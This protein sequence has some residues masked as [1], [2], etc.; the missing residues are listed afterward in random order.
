MP[1]QTYAGH[2]IDLSPKCVTLTL[3]SS[4][5]PDAQVQT[6][7]SIYKKLKGSSTFTL[8]VMQNTKFWLQTNGKTDRQEQICMPRTPT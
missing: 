5:Y 8:C 2:K 6:L 1:P 3:R 4:K 7:S